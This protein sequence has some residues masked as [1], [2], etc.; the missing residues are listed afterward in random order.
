MQPAGY[1][2][3]KLKKM[4]RDCR[5]KSK[6]HLW[7]CLTCYEVSCAGCGNTR[8]AHYKKCGHGLSMNCKCEA[9]CWECAGDPLDERTVPIFVRLW[10]LKHGKKPSDIIAALETAQGMD[11]NQSVQNILNTQ[12][13]LDSKF[14]DY[15]QRMSGMM[16]SF[17]S[18][19]SD[20]STAWGDM[21]D[22][23]CKD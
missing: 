18:I 16:Q 19:V 5:C 6:A 10:A 9:W 11:L 12:G 15:N 17:D 2:D 1:V 8:T 3:I 4:F 23:E 20:L 13:E 22:W 14:N 7:T 21:E